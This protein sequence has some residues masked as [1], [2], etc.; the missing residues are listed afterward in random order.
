MW[1]AGPI[2]DIIIQPKNA[3]GE[4]RLSVG[5][6]EKLRSELKNAGIR[7]KK[8]LGQN[9][10]IDPGVCPAMAESAVADCPA[11]LEIGAGTGTLT[12][13]LAK[14]AEKV[15]AVETDRSLQ[16]ALEK[17]VAPYGNTDLV[18]A[19]FM[20]LDLKRLAEE[21]FSGKPFAVAANIPYYVTTPVI[22]ELLEHEPRPV[23]VTVMVQK[24][25][26]DRFTAPVPSREAGAVTVAVAY[27]T[28]ITRLFEVPRECFYPQPRVDSAVIKM[29][30]RE[31]PPVAAEN[32][33]GMFRLV[34]AGYAERR[35]TFANAA[36]AAGYPKEKIL[37]A[38]ES[39]GLDAN[40]RA[41][42]LSIADWAFIAGKIYGKKG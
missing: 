1:K 18:F 29:R 28:E 6:R 26:A 42:A 5:E 17:A 2:Y 20:S 9:F 36:A 41:E 24:E 21:R 12:V 37:S 14:R 23:S 30:I 19:D 35:K 38:L 22:M 34:K 27:R 40:I 3:K 7:P 11:V 4:S 39:A 13:E 25:A 33:A 10:I 31:H 8:R 15:V 16:P 32:E